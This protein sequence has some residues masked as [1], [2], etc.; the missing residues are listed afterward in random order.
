MGAKPRTVIAPALPSPQKVL[1]AHAFNFA[2]ELAIEQAERVT[3]AV[4]FKRG[5]PQCSM[6]EGTEGYCSNCP[7]PR[8]G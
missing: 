8:E 5:D 6:C 1:E 2:L 3:D 7:P 4:R